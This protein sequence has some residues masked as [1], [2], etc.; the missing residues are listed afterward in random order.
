MRRRIF[1]TEHE[2]FRDA[3][4]EFVARQVTPNLEAWAEAKALPREFWLPAG[5]ED[6]R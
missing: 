2:D 1:E 3:V 4:A 5:S 6:I